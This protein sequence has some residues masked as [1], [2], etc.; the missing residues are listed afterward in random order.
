MNERDEACGRPAAPGTNKDLR[1]ELEDMTQD[2]RQSAEEASSLRMQL[3]NALTLA[4]RA[5]PV[6]RQAPEDRG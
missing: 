4:A 3:V 1:R 2:A 5:A 6:A